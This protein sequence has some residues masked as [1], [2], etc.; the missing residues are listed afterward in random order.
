MEVCWE[1]VC[2]QSQL[3]LVGAGNWGQEQFRKPEA[4]ECPPLE[5]AAT[6]SSEDHDWENEFVCD[7]DL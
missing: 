6:H 5:A 3:R 4:A 7:S 1:I 2:T